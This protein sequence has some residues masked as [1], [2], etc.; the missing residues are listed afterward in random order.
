M[1]RRWK[2]IKRQNF[3]NW[4]LD[5]SRGKK[6]GKKIKQILWKTKEKDERWK[7][8]KRKKWNKNE[9]LK[10]ENLKADLGGK[11]KRKLG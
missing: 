1:K 2:E 7:E 5:N 8:K 11:G 4:N 3:K 6:K 10:E 9:I